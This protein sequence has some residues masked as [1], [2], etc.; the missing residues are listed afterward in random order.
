MGSA[1]SP[2]NQTARFQ[3]GKHPVART[4][5]GLHNTGDA[6]AEYLTGTG[7]IT[8]A[9]FAPEIE[10][11]NKDVLNKFAVLV[12][13]YTGRPAKVVYAGKMSEDTV[14]LSGLNSFALGSQI[15]ISPGGS[16]LLVFFTLDYT[17]RSGGELSTTYGESGLAISLNA[18]RSFLG[19]NGQYL[20]N[21]LLSSLLHEFGHQIGLVHNSDINCIMDLHAG[22]E[23]KPLESY[24][25][26]TPQDFCQQEKDQINAIK[27]KL[28]N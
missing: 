5:L 24:G 28:G 27:L 22:I 6:R 20:D 1:D 7:P 2:F 9:W 26:S 3:L 12:N 15:Q 10:N 13:K 16:K 11:I 8:I 14:N 23:G 4:I 18:H 17:P 19:D 25:D 21:Y